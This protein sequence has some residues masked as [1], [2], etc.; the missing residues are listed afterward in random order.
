M[1]DR[2]G[3]PEYY[4]WVDYAFWHSLTLLTSSGQA[5]GDKEALP[6]RANSLRMN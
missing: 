4:G 5:S 2:R 6:W 1:K 3:Y